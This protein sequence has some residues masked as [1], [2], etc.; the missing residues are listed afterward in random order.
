M[1]PVH[2]HVVNCIPE[3]Y[4]HVYVQYINYVIAICITVTCTFVIYTIHLADISLKQKMEE[5]KQY[6]ED[7]LTQLKHAN[8]FLD[9]DDD[10]ILER[11]FNKL[12]GEC[13]TLTCT[14]C[15]VY[16]GCMD[17]WMYVWMD[18]CMDG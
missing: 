12:T 14:L 16:N 11:I 8:A 4:L 10:G 9:D 6:A 17:G 15:I 18:G 7:R 1:L 5:R 2:V 3:F 13:S